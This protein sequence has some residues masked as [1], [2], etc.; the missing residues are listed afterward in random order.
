[1]K[2][3]EYKQHYLLHNQY[4]YKS[5]TTSTHEALRMHSLYKN[6]FLFF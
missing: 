1:M 3:T 2:F 5:K 6:Y 4:N